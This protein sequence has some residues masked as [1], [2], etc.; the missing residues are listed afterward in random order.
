M[1]TSP[2]LARYI[3]WMKIT[4]FFCNEN[5][6]TWCLC[7]SF[8]NIGSLWNARLQ[9][10]WVYPKVEYTLKGSW[11]VSEGKACNLKRPSNDLESKSNELSRSS[12]IY[13]QRGS[14]GWQRRYMTDV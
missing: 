2:S 12:Y 11:A 7:E 9:T 4:L 3:L 8:A 1:K 14:T 6:A 10:C 13:P 5:D